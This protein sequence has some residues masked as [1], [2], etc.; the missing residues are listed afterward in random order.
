MTDLNY[1]SL[2]LKSKVVEQVSVALGKIL[3]S[4]V[5]EQVSVTSG[6]VIYLL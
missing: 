3:K 2:F 5:V 1:G 6:K 4:K